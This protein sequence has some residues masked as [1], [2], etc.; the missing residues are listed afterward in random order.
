MTCDI[1]NSN[2]IFIKIN[3]LLYNIKI[4]YGKFYT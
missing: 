3:I 2:K 1:D 4:N